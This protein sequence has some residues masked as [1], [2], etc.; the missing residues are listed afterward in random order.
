MK[1]QSYLKI[2]DNKIHASVFDK[3]ELE[4]IGGFQDEDEIGGGFEEPVEDDDEPE[5]VVF[6]LFGHY[7]PS[8][9]EE[10]GRDEI[11][12]R[13]TKEEL[14]QIMFELGFINRDQLR[15]L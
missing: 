2:V 9:S 5:Y 14:L 3:F 6:V 4:A 10:R 11:L 1:A 7:D 12:R 8:K 13:D 15:E